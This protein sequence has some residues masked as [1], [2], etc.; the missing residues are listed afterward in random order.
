METLPIPKWK[1]KNM[2]CNQNNAATS[3]AADT[4]QTLPSFPSVDGSGQPIPD[5]LGNIP[6]TLPSYPHIDGSGLPIDPQPIPP[7]NG[8]NGQSSTRCCKVRFFHAAAQSGPVNVN[9]GSQRV[10]TN[11]AFGNFSSYYCFSEGFRTLSILNARTGR[12]LL[13]QK[14][15]PMNANEV[16]TMVIVNNAATGALEVVR[17]SDSA[18]SG[19]LGGYACLRMANFVLGNRSLDLLMSDGRV[20]FSDVRY[21]ENTLSRR[22]VPGYYQFYVTNTPLRIEPRSTDI[23]LDEARSLDGQYI[24]GYGEVD[25]E[26]AFGLRA[27]RGLMYTAYIIG[28][29][30]TD[31]VQVV[32]A[33][34]S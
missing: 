31:E 1:V 8:Q 11:L 23:E 21:K 24:A 9:V 19:Q 32:V 33:Q 17:V 30:N 15:V 5:D 34:N 26:T 16:I 13:L 29:A 6:Q 14:T 7:T 20:L 22:L 28:Q 4:P 12:T 25:V 18:C 2:N 3:R 10:A 27:R